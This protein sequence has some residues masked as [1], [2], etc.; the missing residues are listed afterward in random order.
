MPGAVTGRERKLTVKHRVT[1]EVEKKKQFL[2]IPYT[3][4]EKQKVIVDGKT[5]RKMKKEERDRQLREQ[6]RRKAAG[7]S[8]EEIAYCMAVEL[9]EEFVEMF[10]E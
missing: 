5:F 9:E 8:E 4:K 3:V 2:G 7:P 1:V 10:G 6:N